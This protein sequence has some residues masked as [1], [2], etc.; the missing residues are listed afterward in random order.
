MA[1]PYTYGNYK[2]RLKS[3]WDELTISDIQKI[4]N[5][6]PKKPYFGM[7]Q[8]LCILSGLSERFWR[9]IIRNDHAFGQLLMMQSEFLLKQ[10]DVNKLPL[11]ECINIAGKFYK[12]PDEEYFL[13]ALKGGQK[14][15]YD[16]EILPDLRRTGDAMPKMTEMLAIV[17]YEQITGEKYNPDNL[18][19]V[20]ETCRKSIF[21]EAYPVCGF[22]LR[23]WISSQETNGKS[24]P[25]FPRLKSERQE[26]NHLINSEA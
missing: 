12:V 17:F 13:S 23:R 18:N 21:V 20:V 2:F 11:P 6:K 24:S 15:S 26:S 9:N 3:S 5:I 8:S 4:N 10:P 22:F 1:T 25:T 14:L 16:F 7:V 19:T